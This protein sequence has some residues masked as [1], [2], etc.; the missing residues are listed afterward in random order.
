MTAAPA[1]PASMTPRT[2]SGVIPPMPS[3]GIPTRCV[4]AST[5]RRPPVCTP[6][7]VGVSNMVPSTRKLAPLDSAAIAPS[8][9]CTELPISLS[10]P[11]SFL[12]SATPIA[13]SPS[14][15]PSTLLSSATST[16]SFT[17]RRD[18]PSVTARSLRARSNSSPAGISFSLSCTM[19]TPASTAAD[20]VAIRSTEA[21]RVRSVTMHRQGSGIR[22]AALTRPLLPPLRP[23]WTALPSRAARSARHCKPSCRP[24]R[25]A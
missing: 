2:L 15:T 8:T 6:G 5:S 10:G 22:D 3:T 13:S 7:W 19:P 20:T 11:T 17:I 12:A 23:G 16:L 1:A 4:T 18:L 14:C 24:Q 25:R 9:L 21:V